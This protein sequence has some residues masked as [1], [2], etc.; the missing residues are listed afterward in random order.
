MSMIEIVGGVMD[1]SATRWYRDPLAHFLLAGLA[2]FLGLSV[3]SDESDNPRE[4]RVDRETLLTFVQYRT[5]VFQPELAARRLDAMSNEER[6]NLVRQ[7]VEE[8]ALY[9]E[10][11]DMGLEGDDYVIRR[12]IVQ[13]LEFITQGFVEQSLDIDDSQLQTFFDQQRDDYFIEPSIT[14]TH[15]F[16]SAEKHPGAQLQQAATDMLKQ[17]HEQ[18]VGFSRAMRYGDRFP[19]HVNY[20][21]RTPEFVAS[22]FGQNFA[23]EVFAIELS[24]GAEGPGWFGP[25]SSSYGLHL[26]NVSQRL[27]G[28]YPSLDEVRE[29]VLQDYRQSQI[30]EKQRKAIAEIVARYQVV[31]S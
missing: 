21:E 20:V 31:E 18:K 11:L 3:V 27:P 22:H 28:R 12:R 13:K 6:S 25:F 5:K 30:R 23:D 10:A 24:I 8:E 17:L 1:K 7:F 26:V 4:I 9:R 14:F 29:M 15:V 19:F 2:L 16:L